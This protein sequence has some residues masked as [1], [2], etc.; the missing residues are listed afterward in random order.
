MIDND[1]ALAQLLNILHI[2]TSQKNRRVMTFVVCFDKITELLLHQN[3][4]ADCGFIKKENLWSMDKCGNKLALHALAKREL[5]NLYVE[6]IS[7][8]Q[9]LN[10]LIKCLLV[11]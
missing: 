10:Q 2:M 5:A 9:K 1:H 4:K 11:G 3:I 6:D 7:D 8:I